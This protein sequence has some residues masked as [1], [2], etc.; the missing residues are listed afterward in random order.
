MRYLVLALAACFPVFPAPRLLIDANKV[1]EL[2]RLVTVKG[3][4]HEE[5]L[6][7]LRRKV[8][9]EGGIRGAQ[10]E[11]YGRAYQATM[12]AFLHQI[13]GD[14]KYCTLAYDAL[15]AVYDGADSETLLPEQGYGLARATVGSGFAYAYDWC[16]D[17]WTAAQSG[18]V[19]QRLR[20][21][22]DAWL[23][24]RH[25]NVEAGH[26]GSNWVS[27]CRGGEL[28][29]LL[30]LRLEHRHAERYQ[31]VKRDLL[32]HMRNF[33]DLG[34][35]QEGIGY[36]AYGG[37]FLLRALL[38]LRS[39]ADMELEEEAARHAWW[40]QAMY[41]GVFADQGGGRTW[42]MSGVSNSGIGDEGWASLL[43]AF[44]PRTGTPYYKW[45]YER[46]LG[47]LSPGPPERRFDP[48]REGPVWAMIYYP[49]DTDERDPSGVFPA[50]VAGQAGLVFFRNRW[51][52]SDDLLLSF[53][54]DSHWHSHAW[55]QPE[56]LQFNL[57]AYGTS[58]AG[59][60]EKTRDAINFSTLLI[61]GRHVAEKARSTT[62][63]LV[64]FTPTPRGATVVASGGSQYASLGAE[65][66]RSFAVEF[67]DGNRARVSFRDRVESATPRVCTWQ[68]N[69]GN[70]ASDGGIRFTEQG[71]LNTPRGRVQVNV[72]A[73][74]GAR[75]QP[76]D[77]F[78]VEAE[79]ASIDLQVEL[80]VDPVAQPALSAGVPGSGHGPEG[81][82]QDMREHF[83]LMKK[84]G[85]HNLRQSIPLPEWPMEKIVRNKHG[86]AL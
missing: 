80:N 55:D 56:A 25:A 52:D 42:L 78:R 2:R 48:R 5:M 4:A 13:T 83:R 7:Q 18:W 12:A 73:P 68:M 10:N 16:R 77:P 29:E 43:F 40:K 14:V 53:H 85:F 46:H 69:L 49:A 75:I 8:E 9:T 61:D 67:L 60:P 21:A 37:I 17:A 34:V 39:V 79:G 50:A 76:G 72:I 66:T 30:A 62:G 59:G 86:P 26:K 36:T 38:A 70:H 84:L 82:A 19:E 24:F 57:F 33:D 27:V 64:S 32:R 81:T 58:F 63:K 31:Q 45:W 51:K 47:R 1:A 22:L 35:S 71:V 65:V 54:A 23:S 28:I 41:A 20:A 74:K 44:V 11:N 6:G 3:S 15:R